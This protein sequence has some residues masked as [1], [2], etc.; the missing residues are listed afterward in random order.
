MVRRRA[1]NP[2]RLATGGY[3]LGIVAIG[4]Q[5]VAIRFQAVE[6]CEKTST[7]WRQVATGEAS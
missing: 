4:C 2:H 3:G 1:R 5:A 6:A 7:V